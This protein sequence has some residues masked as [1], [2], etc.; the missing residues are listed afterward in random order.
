MTGA[1]RWSG[2]CEQ[3]QDQIIAYLRQCLHAETEPAGCS[4]LV[5]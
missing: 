2:R 3:L 4:L 1:R 5:Q